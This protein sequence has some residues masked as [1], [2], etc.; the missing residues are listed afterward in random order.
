MRVCSLDATECVYTHT[1]QNC[2]PKYASEWY[3]NA[4]FIFWAFT[5]PVIQCIM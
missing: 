2:K 4:N 5:F 3:G 1:L